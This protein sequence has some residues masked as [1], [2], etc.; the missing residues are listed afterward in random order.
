M[1][2]AQLDWVDIGNVD[3]A[4]QFKSVPAGWLISIT[5]RSDCHEFEVYY[6]QDTE[7]FPHIRVSSFNTAKQ[8]CQEQYNERQYNEH[9]IKMER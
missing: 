9:K 1:K 3:G 4:E 7:G 2:F 8:I 5:D 6:R